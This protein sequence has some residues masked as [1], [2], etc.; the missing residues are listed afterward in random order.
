MNARYPFSTLVPDLLRA[1]F[2]V[3]VCGAVALH[4]GL[5]AWLFWIVGVIGI[6]FAVFG[7]STA[8]RSTMRIEVLADEVVFHPG[9]KTVRLSNLSQLRLEYFST[10]RDAERGWM[11][12]TFGDQSGQYIRVDSRLEHFEELVELA[13]RAA[14]KNGLD[15]AASTVENLS[16]MRGAR[17]GH[18]PRGSAL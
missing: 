18:D 12:L 11:Q 16:A 10:R 17:A 9:P 3:T 8:L 13:A 15:M 7:V 2:G 4:V 6:A 1:L 14:N 5:D